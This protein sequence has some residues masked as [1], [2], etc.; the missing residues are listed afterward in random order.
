ST[1]V[2]EWRASIRKRSHTYKGNFDAFLNELVPSRT[3]CPLPD[4]D[5]ALSIH[6]GSSVGI[7][8]ALVSD[9]P[10]D[11]RL[12]F[13]EGHHQAVPF[14]YPNF[15]SKHHSTRPD[16]MVSFPGE[17]LY[18]AKVRPHNWSQFSMVV[19]VEDAA[20]KDP[21]AGPPTP[22]KDNSLLQLSLNARGL[23]LEHGFLAAFVIGVYGDAVRI[24]RFDQACAVA[25][26]R[27]DIKTKEGLKGV[28]DFF[29]RFVHPWEA[30]P[31][32]VV[33]HDATMRKLTA[34]DR[35]WLR[36]RLGSEASSLLRGCNLRRHARRVLIWDDALD[37]TEARARAII[38][39][40]PIDVSGRVFSRSTMV[41]LGVE[42]TRVEGGPDSDEGEELQLC[43]LKEAWRKLSHP[44][45]KIFYDRLMETISRNGWIGLP[46]MVCGGDLGEIEARHYEGACSYERSHTRL[47]V[48][49]VGRPLS[50]FK[51]TK[52]LAMV[53]RDALRG[54]LLALE[55]GGVLHRDISPGNILIV[56]RPVKGC[57][58]V[59][60]IHDFDYSW[61]PSEPPRKVRRTRR[62]RPIELPPTW[63]SDENGDYDLKQTT[64]THYFIAVQF[65]DP[66]QPNPFHAAYHD[67][68]S[69]FWVL[70]FIVL[71]HTSHD[72]PRGREAWRIVFTSEDESFAVS[73]KRRWV[74][75][76]R[77]PLQITGNA[78]LTELLYRFGELVAHQLRSDIFLKYDEVLALF[79]KAID[80]PDWPKNDAA[81]P[82]SADDISLD[83]FLP[84][85]A[86]ECSTRVPAG[87]PSGPRGEKRAR[88]DS[89]SELTELVSGMASASKTIASG[90]SRAPKRQKTADSEMP[91]ASVGS[92]L[93]SARSTTAVSGI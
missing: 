10:E 33:G 66:D 7:F 91:L 82:Y 31:R 62:T 72:H 34:D 44:S 46:Q 38:V 74:D 80:R 41:W 67:I 77:E 29:W 79:D 55:N 88:S 58:S 68:E 71:R 57:S 76:R 22:F 15:A 14:P 87:P 78:P 54:H 39:F 18:T 16:I 84:E 4:P 37:S 21:F 52:Q 92:E 85:E 27:L 8:N 63:V 11:K 23:L 19:A 28:R 9:F 20:H 48:N 47:V 25:S 65:M 59:G 69:F 81:I 90:S 42:D 64:G 86:S 56:D 3:P 93:E 40:K 2:P 17:Y 1:Q 13:R 26:P 24:A 50:R 51:S 45:E 70:L 83:E 61:M 60:V 75:Y 5:N 30:R 89:D 6:W 53:M 12:S 32:A 43:V 36:R 73:D 35:S 49:V